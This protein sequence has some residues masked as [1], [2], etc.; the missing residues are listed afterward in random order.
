MAKKSTLSSGEEVIDQWITLLL[1]KYFPEEDPL[2]KSQELKNL[3][4]LL[5]LQ[6]LI[7]SL[8]L[9]KT[10]TKPAVYI[11]LVG[12]LA[13]KKSVFCDHGHG[14]ELSPSNTHPEALPGSCC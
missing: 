13:K 2:E 4:N 11:Q 6:N 5:G 14:V 8:S 3:I 1:T 9:N 10:E 7:S 12:E